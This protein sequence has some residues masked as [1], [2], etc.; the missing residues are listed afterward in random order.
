MK[1]LVLTK[2]QYMGKDL[3]DDY[4]GRFRELPLELARLGHEVQGLALS[5]RPRAEGTFVDGD[6]SGSAR[7]IWH[8][9]NLMNG[10]L[11]KFQIYKRR[12]LQL[13]HEFQPDLIWACSDA[14]HAIFGSWLAKQVGA[15]CVIDLYDNFESFSA[16]RLPGVLPL[17]RRAVRGA[18]GVTS[19]SQR[20]AD[21][22]VRTY[23]RTKPTSIIE[24]GVR[25]ELFYPQDPNLCRQQLGLP[26]NAKI[27]GTAGALDR[28]RG[29]ETLFKAFEQLSAE[30]DDLHLVLAGPRERGLSIPAG[31]RVHDLNEL[32][33]AEVPLLFGSL[34]VAV[35]C[36]RHSAQGEYSFPQKAYEIIAC[37]V[38]LVAAAVGSMN[39]LLLKYSDCLYEPDD[40]ASLANAIRRQLHAR[41]IIELSTPS[42]ANSARRLSDFFL[43]IVSGDS[44]SVTQ[45]TNN[46]AIG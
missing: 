39:E 37:R 27:V 32:P 43:Q 41:T 16:S 46:H 8:S 9:V 14:Y 7:V 38:P 29:I 21:Y 13:S 25:K 24:N 12:S 42:W 18:D 6:G 15:R 28:S 23:M 20:L 40:S 44:T 5:Y 11:P 17:F 10:V 45:T 30:V 3:I 31:P 1:I 19:F 33:H 36:Y 2:R 34:N 26:A 4:F 35:V 22:V